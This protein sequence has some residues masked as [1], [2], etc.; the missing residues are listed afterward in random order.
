MSY[1]TSKILLD[2]LIV[3]LGPC[4]ATIR[5]S[6]KTIKLIKSSKIER[7][8]LTTKKRR[9]KCILNCWIQSMRIKFIINQNQFIV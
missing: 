3:K 2:K 8:S 1:L 4:I 7:D 6:I 9:K 5:T